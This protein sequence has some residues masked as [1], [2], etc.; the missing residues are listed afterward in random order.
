MTTTTVQGI[1]VPRFDGLGRCSRLNLVDGATVIGMLA[2]LGFKY[3]EQFLPEPA[4]IPPGL[5][6][7]IDPPSGSVVPYGSTVVVWNQRERSGDNTT[8]PARGVTAPTQNS[9]GRLAACE[10][11]P[12]MM[13]MARNAALKVY[14]YVPPDSQLQTVVDQVCQQ[15]YG[16]G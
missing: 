12:Q 5:V 3:Q 16:S 14:G 7:R 15:Y 13:Q 11:D 8:V 6:L 1:T 4:P 9:P 2:D 10:S